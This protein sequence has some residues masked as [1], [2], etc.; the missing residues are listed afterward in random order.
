MELESSLTGLTH[1]FVTV[2][3]TGFAG[4]IV[5]PG[6][7]DVTMLALC[8]GRDQCSLAIYLTGF[9]QAIT[10]VGA[11]VMTPLIGKLS[12]QYGRK[13]LLTL[14]LTVSIIPVVILAYSR[15]TNFF[16]VY[17]ATRTLAAMAGES[18]VNCLALAYV[19][20]KVPHR[21]RA[22]AF[23][24]L[25]GVGSASFVC[26][27][28]AARFLSTAS[29]FQVAALSSM[30]GVVYMRIFLKESV[31][32]GDL[33][34]LILKE[35]EEEEC[36][37]VSSERTTGIFKRLPSIGD[38][39]S[40]LK[41]CPT[42]SQA[43]VVLFFNG[44]ADSGIQASLMYYLKARF[45]FSKDQFA[46][47]LLITGI[48]ATVAQLLFM[49]L[50][51]PAMGEEKLLSTGLLLGC[52]GTFSYSISWSPWVPYAIAGCSVFVVFVRPSICSIA[53]KLVGPNEQGMVQG[54]LTGISS[55]ANIISPLIFSPLTALF[56]SEEAPFN[57]PGF[58]IMCLGL[59]LMVGLIQSILIWAVP[60]NA[61]YKTNCIINRN[62]ALV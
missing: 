33:R 37:D 25:A 57:F 8:P 13:T 53:S 45:Q 28:L 36:A 47:L 2:F 12:D 54:C 14:P 56:L 30:I 41:C 4:C 27:T 21:K 42:F 11:V 43:A 1:L 44:L 23:G 18:C 46:D 5:I 29:A 35:G 16:Y 6:I 62:D 59:V 34:Q 38:L 40:L 49:P 24:I 10:G 20:D 19:A 52:I 32:G 9:Q 39:I 58:S 55:F 17:F 61:G 7:T 60:S 3:L 50:L 22:S 31:G 26:G 48:G 15:D 51:V